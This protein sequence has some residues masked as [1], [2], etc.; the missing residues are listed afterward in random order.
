MG[1][2]G[3]TSQIT[4]LVV[5][6][7]LP[8]TARRLSLSLFLSSFPACQALISLFLSP[9]F[10]PTR[11]FDSK[12]S[13]RLVALARILLVSHSLAGVRLD[14]DAGSSLYESP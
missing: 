5:V 13:D 4:Q 9:A 6:P 12:E 1:R 3:D 8:A 7:L 2:F 10:V 11:A 14:P